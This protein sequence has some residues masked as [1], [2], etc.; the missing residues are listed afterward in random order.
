M[1]VILNTQKKLKNYVE[2][3]AWSSDNYFKR[4]EDEYDDAISIQSG[5]SSMEELPT[6][7]SVYM[8]PLGNWCTTEQWRRYRENEWHEI[9]KSY[10]EEL[11]TMQ[12]AYI[13]Y[14]TKRGLSNRH[15]KAILG[16]E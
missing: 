6:N 16:S 13:K 4:D 15:I 14:A 7:D 8:L 11:L 9:K 5:T 1:A 3:Y 10:E 12:D 2:F